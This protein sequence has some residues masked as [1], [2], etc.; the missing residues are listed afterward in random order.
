MVARWMSACPAIEMNMAGWKSDLI[1]RS[2]DICSIGVEYENASD[3]VR[4][5]QEDAIICR[6]EDR[7][8]SSESVE[9]TNA[10]MTD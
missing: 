2:G 6:S 7:P 5:S 1:G 4:M 8:P 3:A 10:E 9:S